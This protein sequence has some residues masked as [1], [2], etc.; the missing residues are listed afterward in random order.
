MKK[1]EYILPGLDRSIPRS[2]LAKADRETQL[3]VMRTW[4]FQNFEDPAERTPYESREGGYI[5]IWGG[6]HEAREE[7]EEEFQDVVP[8]DVIEELSGELNT[9]CWEWAPTEKPGDYDEFL[10]DDIAQITEFY[11]NYS[12]GILDIEALLKIR[13]SS[14]VENCFCRLLYVNVITAME[15]YLSDA[16][17]NSVVPEK[18]L[19]RRF[20]ENSPEFKTEKLSLS[21]IFKAAEE[22]EQKVKSHLADVVWHNLSRVKPMYREVLG[23][24]F[25]HDIGDLT[26]AVLKRHDIVHRNGKSKTGEE[27]LVASKNVFD[28][29]DKVDAFVQAVDQGLS[30]ARANNW[31]NKDFK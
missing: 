12:S 17:I 29:I 4:F 20:V 28:L 14:S 25:P 2:E 26:R 13:I 24:T 7:I 15:T 21:Q 22:I 18:H 23:V 11:H 5:W 9:M 19:M 30:E 16:F 10:V 6:P 8:E 3:E 27:I 1:S 31:G